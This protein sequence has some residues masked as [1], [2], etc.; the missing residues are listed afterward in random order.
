[1]VKAI[2][3]DYEAR[4]TVNNTSSFGKLREPMLRFANWARACNATSASGDWAVGNTSDPGTRLGQS[5]LR[6]PTVFNFFRPGY[7]P[8]NTAMGTAGL[9]APEF[10][11]T[12]ASSVVGYVNFMQRVVSNGIG[13]VKG[14][15]GTLLPL[16]K[17]AQALLGEINLVLAAGQIGTANLAA[18]AGAV[19][20][21]PQNSDAALNRRIQTALLMV[22]ASPE[23]IVQK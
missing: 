13:D 8:P 5:P 19:N 9:M 6:S 22:L 18:L 2:L 4:N 7:V 3:L 16:A 12:N 10:Q 15:Y 14:D 20:G 11:I 23:Y 17:N 21:M 1:V